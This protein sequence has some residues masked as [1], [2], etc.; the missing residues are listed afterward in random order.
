MPTEEY[1][2]RRTEIYFP[3]EDFLKKWKGWAKA[4][5]TPLS[6]WIFETVER[7][8][9]DSGEPIQD[10]AKER[11]S[12]QDENRKLRRDLE[13]AT[14]L[15]EAYKTEAFNLRNEI[16]LQKD[17]R[18]RGQFDDRLVAVLRRGGVWRSRDLLKELDVDAKDVDAIQIVVKQLQTLQDIGIVQE[19][20]NGWRW[21]G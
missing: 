6:S 17:L 3:S 7:V 8:M 2:G 20:S 15:M 4:A 21:V 1:R 14:T 5:K 9:D 12:L 11:S 16:F 19:G 13:N 18:G 10:I